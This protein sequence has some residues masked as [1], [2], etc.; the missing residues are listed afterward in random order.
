MNEESVK[1]VVNPL[2]PLKEELPLK[3]SYKYKF[4]AFRRDPPWGAIFLCSGCLALCLVVLIL[5]IYNV[6]EFS[7]T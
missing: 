6:K 5:L 4:L 2:I 7:M 3:Q 1:I